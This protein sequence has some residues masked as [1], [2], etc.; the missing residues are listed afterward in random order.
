MNVSYGVILIKL[1][2]YEKKILMINKKNSLCYRFYERK[3]IK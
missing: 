2:K 3:N 1:D